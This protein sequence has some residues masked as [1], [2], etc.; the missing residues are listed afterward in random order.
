MM[1]EKNIESTYENAPEQMYPDSFFYQY[2]K[3][4]GFQREVGK[5]LGNAFFVKSV[6]DMGCACGWYLEGVKESGI[7]DLMGFEYVYSMAQKYFPENVSSNIQYGD[8][9]KEINLNRKF[10]AVISFEVG[11]H[12]PET[13]AEVYIKNLTRHASRHLFFSVSDSMDGNFHIN[14]KPRSYWL[15]LLDQ[16]G[17]CVSNEDTGKLRSLFRVVPIRNKYKGYMAKTVFALTPK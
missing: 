4:R 5:L 15:N 1:D 16:N 11:E 17:F 13:Y 2:R 14:I 3:S 10:D 12:L 6:L 9:T 8:L 7:E